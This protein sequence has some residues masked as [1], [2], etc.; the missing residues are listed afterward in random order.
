MSGNIKKYVKAM[1]NVAN[2][3]N[4]ISK[5][6]ISDENKHQYISCLGGQGGYLGRKTIM[7]LGEIKEK[8]DYR[9]KIKNPD[10]Y[11]GVKAIIEDGKKDRRNNNIG[12]AFGVANP[13]SGACNRFLNKKM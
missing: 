1:V 9:I 8:N 2:S 4:K 5:K 3:Y 12:S 6:G 13:Q 11:G 10:K 7:T